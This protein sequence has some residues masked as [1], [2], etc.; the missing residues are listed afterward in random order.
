MWSPEKSSREALSKGTSAQHRAA[1]WASWPRWG[2]RQE[3]S[4]CAAHSARADSGTAH[5]QPYLVDEPIVHQ[6]CGEVLGVISCRGK[7]Q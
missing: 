3:A 4:G 6:L 2:I 5:E 1:A 7:E